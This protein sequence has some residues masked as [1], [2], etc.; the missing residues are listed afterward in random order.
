MVGIPKG[1]LDSM[2][3]KRLPPATP[4]RAVRKIQATYG[5]ASK[6]ARACHITPQAVNQWREVPAQ[7]VMTITKIIGMRPDEIRPDIFKARN[8]H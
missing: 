7:H 6:I 2:P 3:A 1:E 4:D 5:L 8:N